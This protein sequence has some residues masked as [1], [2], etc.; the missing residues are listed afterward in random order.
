MSLYKELSPYWDY[1][2]SIRKLETY[3]SLDMKFP[4]K[5][6]FPKSL[7]E[8]NQ[9]VPFDV[10]DTEIKGLSFVSQI[11]D[12]DISE[13]LKVIGKIIKLNKEREL[14]EKL[15]RETVDKLKSTFE[16]TD[17]EKLKNLYFDFNNDQNDELEL[18]G[19][20]ALESETIELD[21]K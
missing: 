11:S 15:F 16:K 1:I 12:K 7:V 9:I 2:H 10:N 14:K 4:I 13:T 21:S 8:S 3:L 5:W 17:L 20:S 18:N 19:T 6:M